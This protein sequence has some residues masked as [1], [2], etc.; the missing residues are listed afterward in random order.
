[1]W[2]HMI[3][4]KWY[5]ST[6]MRLY[7]LKLKWCWLMKRTHQQ[8]YSHD[9]IVAGLHDSWLPNLT[10]WWPMVWSHHTRSHMRDYML[11]FLKA[12]GNNIKATF[13]FNPFVVAYLWYF[14]NNM[15]SVITLLAFDNDNVSSIQIFRLHT[16]VLFNIFLFFCAKVK[17][18]FLYQNFYWKSTIC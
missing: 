3:N 10:G 4:K 5:I 11:D 2:G 18:E 6:S 12:V 14:N 1:M 16:W 9:T 15:F 7:L 8:Q 17:S 13:P